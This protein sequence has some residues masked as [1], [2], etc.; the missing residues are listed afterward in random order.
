MVGA[1]LPLSALTPRTGATRLRAGAW[2]GLDC[3]V[4][5]A[6]PGGRRRDPGIVAGRAGVI[7]KLEKPSAIERLD[8]IVALSD[9]VMVARGD[10]GVEMPPEQVPPIQRRIVRACRE[11]GKPSIVATQMLESMIQT[12]PNPRRSVRCRLG[13]LSWCGRCDAVSGIGS[14]AV[15]LEAVAMM[16]RII[17]EAERD[18]PTIG[19]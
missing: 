4:L 11:A 14:G 12:R 17:T 19:A 2:R 5:R 10:L 16:D 1:V 15:P 13:H 18:P 8:A 7:S 9:A 6:A 3:A